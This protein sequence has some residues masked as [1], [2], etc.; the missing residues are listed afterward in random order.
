MAHGLMPFMG[1][2][3]VTHAPSARA[4]CGDQ[5]RETASCQEPLAVAVVGVFAYRIL[6]MW[7]PMPASL[8]LWPKVRGIGQQPTRHPGGTPQTDEQT[9]HRKA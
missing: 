2:R 9:L 1:Q 8:A 5:S 3:Y 4:G 7:L 6:A